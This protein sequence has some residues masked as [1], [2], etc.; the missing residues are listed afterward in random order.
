MN[1]ASGGGKM[2]KLIIVAAAFLIVISI[3]TIALTSCVG[4]DTEKPGEL[5]PVEITEY[6]GQKLSSVDDFR[7]NSI[8]GPQYLD[9]GSYQLKVNGLV[10]KPKSKLL[11][12]TKTIRKW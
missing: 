11:A 3:C 8:K 4:R 10:E 7:E 12:R 2:K 9:I 5:E 6:E 1:V